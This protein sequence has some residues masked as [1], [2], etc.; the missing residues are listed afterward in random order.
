MVT[1]GYGPVRLDSAVHLWFDRIIR[2]TP[3]GPRA[4]SVR[5][6]HGNFQCVSHPMGPVRGPCGTRKG[7]ARLSYG[8]V[9]E[10]VFVTRICK[11]PHGRCIWA[12]GACTDP[13]RSPHGLFKG[14]L[15]S[16]NPYGARKLKMSALKLCGPRTGRQKSYGDARNSWMDVRF[17]FQTAREQPVRG[18]GVWCD[19]GIIS[20]YTRQYTNKQ[21]LQMACHREVNE[22][23][24]SMAGCAE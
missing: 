10:L 19:W 12:Y 18:P 4:M 22:W 17:L 3:H 5:A 16:R 20:D 9:R 8:H 14:C 6:L 11:I 2:R 21:L 23:N 15:R 1:S 24:I 13:L 7:V